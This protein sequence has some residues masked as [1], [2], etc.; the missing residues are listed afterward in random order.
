M[1]ND[2]RYWKNDIR[3]SL[4]GSHVIYVMPNKHASVSFKSAVKALLEE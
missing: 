2:L 4:F 3:K 1:K